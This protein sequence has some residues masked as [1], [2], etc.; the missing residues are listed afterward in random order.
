MT[1]KK[2]K[3]IHTAIFWSGI[4]L[5]L[6]VLFTCFKVVIIP[7]TSMVPT[8]KVGD[9]LLTNKDKD[10]ERG[11]VVIFYNTID[12]ERSIYIKRCIGVA[13]D[14]IGVHN[15]IVWR[16]GQAL[17]EPYLNEPYINGEFEDI[18]VPEGMMFVMG[19]NRNVSYDSRY[20]GCVPVSDVIGKPILKFG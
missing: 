4:L 7:S 17:D 18:T 14:T 6:L 15:G 11:D 13:G 20:F 2:F 12:G 8:Y 3:I 9:V 16:N 5:T 10:V 1:E 19:D